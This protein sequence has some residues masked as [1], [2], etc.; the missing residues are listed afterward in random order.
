[1]AESVVLKN[2]K[3]DQALGKSSSDNPHSGLNIYCREFSKSKP[4]W[5]TKIPKLDQEEACKHS[6][7]LGVEEHRLKNSSITQFHFPSSTN[8][9]FSCLFIYLSIIHLLY[10]NRDLASLV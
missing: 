4:P 8:L 5:K 10:E 2:Y 7:V 1:M 6:E 3:A 9:I